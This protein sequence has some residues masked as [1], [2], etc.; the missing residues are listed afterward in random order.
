[1]FKTVGVRDV[2]T[3]EG[4][5]EM[6]A[7]AAARAVV[8][9]RLVD[10]EAR[11]AP[12]VQVTDG[13]EGGLVLDPSGSVVATAL[14]AAV[15]RQGPVDVEGMAVAVPFVFPENDPVGQVHL[16]G[17]TGSCH[18]SLPGMNVSSWKS[19]IVYAARS[20]REGAIVAR[21]LT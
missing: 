2:F 21:V 11:L 17:D 19:G 14:A 1:A 6:L 8:Q 9:R 18:G 3:L 16:D 7:T 5:D 12:Q 20:C 15:L 4:W 10:P 13:V